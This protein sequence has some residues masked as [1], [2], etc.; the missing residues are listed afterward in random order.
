V[1]PTKPLI[2]HLYEIMM[3][4]GCAYMAVINEMFG[5]GIMSAISFSVKVKRE[6]GDWE[7]ERVCCDHHAGTMVSVDGQSVVEFQLTIA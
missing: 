1:P 2:Y 4:Y 6:G 5:D 3:V 7:S